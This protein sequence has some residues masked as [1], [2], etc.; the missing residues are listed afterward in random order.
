QE[1][2][3]DDVTLRA[4]PVQNTAYFDFTLVES[5]PVNLFIYNNEGKVVYQE[6][7][8][9]GKGNSTWPVALGLHFVGGLYYFR[10]EFNHAWYS[11]SMIRLNH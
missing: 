1:Q 10:I 9:L 11:G 5:R 4:N 7:R 8:I 6:Q 3:F 2:F